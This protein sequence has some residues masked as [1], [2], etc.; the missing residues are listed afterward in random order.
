STFLADVI[1]ELPGFRRATLMPAFGRREQELDETCLRAFDRFAYVAQ[2]HVRY[3]DWTGQLCA[4]YGL[5]P[6][7]LVRSLLDAVVSLRDH[8][9]RES[10]VVPSLVAEPHHAAMSDAQLERMIARLALPWY[11][12]FYMSWRR[13]PDAL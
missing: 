13:S 10:S 2:N 6:I 4:D 11:L 7:V 3:S 8:L 9:R 1:A 12:G 5:T